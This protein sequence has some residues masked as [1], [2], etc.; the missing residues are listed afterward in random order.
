MGDKEE[1]NNPYHTR[2]YKIPVIGHDKVFEMDKMGDKEKL[3]THTTPKI[4]TECTL[5]QKP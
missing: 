5:D 1:V 3:T 4:P 2:S